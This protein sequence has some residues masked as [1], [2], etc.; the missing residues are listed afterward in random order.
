VMHDVHPHQYREP[1]LFFSRTTI[2][3][4]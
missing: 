3:H 2:T 4:N 1:S